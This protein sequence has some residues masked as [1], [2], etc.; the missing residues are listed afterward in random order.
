MYLYKRDYEKSI[1]NFD[2]LFKA[3]EGKQSLRF[4]IYDVAE[5]IELDVPSRNT[6]IKISGE[7]LK[8]LEDQHVNF[9]LNYFV[10][11]HRK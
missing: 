2:T 9:K 3:H 8:I 7:L 4:V 6:K 10:N 11:W 5:E 1:Q